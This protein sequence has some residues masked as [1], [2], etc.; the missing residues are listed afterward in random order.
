MP[1]QEL[2]SVI[3]RRK[4]ALAKQKDAF[5]ADAPAGDP[6]R[7]KRLNQLQLTRKKLKRAQR[8]A[9]KQKSGDAS[10]AS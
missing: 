9:Q 8:R 3:E 6:D 10:D 4:A 5:P 1:K 7:Q 2:T